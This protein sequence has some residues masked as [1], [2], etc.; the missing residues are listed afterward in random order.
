MNKKHGVLRAFV[1]GS[2]SFKEGYVKVR[3]VVLTLAIA[4]N[5]P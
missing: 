1:V 5:N 3:L 4:N 2:T